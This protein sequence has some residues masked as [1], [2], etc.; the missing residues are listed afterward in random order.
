[1]AT[2]GSWK[3]IKEKIFEKGK[4]ACAKLGPTG[5][6]NADLGRKK[7]KTDTVPALPTSQGGSQ[8]IQPHALIPSSFLHGELIQKQTG[9]VGSPHRVVNQTRG[10]TTKEGGP[11]VARNKKDPSHSPGLR[12]PCLGS[13]DTPGVCDM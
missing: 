9:S 2:G 6:G 5:E 10:A 3:P 4:D 11:T 13:K 1:M 7:T 8:G 12:G